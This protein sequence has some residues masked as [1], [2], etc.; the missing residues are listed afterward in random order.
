MTWVKVN[1]IHNAWNLQLQ[2]PLDWR[3]ASHL[4]KLSSLRPSCTNAST[5]RKTWRQTVNA[6][7]LWKKSFILHR[8]G[9]CLLLGGC[10]ALCFFAES[11]VFLEIC[12]DKLVL[13]G[14]AFAEAKDRF[15][16][17]H[18][19]SLITQHEG[20][21]FDA[22]FSI[23][24]RIAK[25]E[26][27]CF[28]FEMTTVVVLENTERHAPVLD[29]AACIY[30]IPHVYIHIQSYTYH[31]YIYVILIYGPRVSLILMHG[32]TTATPNPDCM[33]L[34][35]VAFPVWLSVYLQ[36]CLICSCIHRAGK[37]CLGC[38]SVKIHLMILRAWTIWLSGLRFEPCLNARLWYTG[39][40]HVQSASA[41]WFQ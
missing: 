8:S 29:H 12:N 28:A 38:S 18:D 33:D 26:W 25:Q 35:G 40:C 1:H 16:W 2:I 5:L 30:C 9:L 37:P 31:I 20:W 32:C 11:V 7:C 41:L 4:V 39:T 15:P 13:G 17:L 21:Q 36:T 22:D 3:Q 27:S 6:L 19:A 14:V 24:C 10:F 23:L 34:H